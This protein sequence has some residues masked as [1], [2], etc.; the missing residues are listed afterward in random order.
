MKLLCFDGSLRLKDCCAKPAN[1]VREASLEEVRR[2]AEE[3]GW[4]LLR[5]DR[6]PT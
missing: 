1:R 3:R 6:D 5:M 4:E 2:W